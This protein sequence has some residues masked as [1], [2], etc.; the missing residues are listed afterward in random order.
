MNYEGF[1]ID[2]NYKAAKPDPGDYSS[3]P[4][5]NFLS[6]HHSRC[7][8][9]DQTFYYTGRNLFMET[10]FSKFY[11]LR[12]K[13]NIGQSNCCDNRKNTGKGAIFWVLGLGGSLSSLTPSF[14]DYMDKSELGFFCNFLFN[15]SAYEKSIKKKNVENEFFYIFF[16]HNFF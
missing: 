15:R 12:D 13:S 14:R 2:L 16:L 7:D 3:K 6:I 11:D 5:N 8:S 4:P 10:T 1:H 9:M